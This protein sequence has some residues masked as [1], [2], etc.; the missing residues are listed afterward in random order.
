MGQPNSKRGTKDTF[1]QIWKDLI[2]GKMF[3][4]HPQSLNMIFNE[5][6][7]R[8]I[9]EVDLKK[10]M[11]KIFEGN[12]YYSGKNSRRIIDFKGNYHILEITPLYCKGFIVSILL[13]DSNLM[14]YR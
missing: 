2:L 10:F 7:Y 8:P 12:Y 3:Q 5:P 11:N 6:K 14:L 1:L 9:I 4:H 13:C